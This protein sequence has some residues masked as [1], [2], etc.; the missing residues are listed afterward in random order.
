MKHLFAGLSRWAV[1]LALSCAA[2]FA[3]DTYKIRLSRI[4]V[5]NSNL[6]TVTGDGEATVT[7]SGAKLTVAGKFS[8]LQ[9]S[10]TVAHIHQGVKMGV[11]GNPILDLTVT[12][13]AQGDL[14]GS[15]NLTPAQVESLKAGRLYIQI[16]SEKA[17]DGNLW[18]WITK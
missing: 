3:Q 12:K 10:A 7:L 5:D 8:G 11:R 2:L 1:A 13:A 16:H 14:S 4:P 15:L 9:S 17:P 18:G 6:R